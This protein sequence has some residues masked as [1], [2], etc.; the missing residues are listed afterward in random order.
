MGSEPEPV[1]RHRPRTLNEKR[2]EQAE[3]RQV[4]HFETILA[5]QSGMDEDPARST[6]AIIL[7]DIRAYLGR[8]GLPKR[9]SEDEVLKQLLE[10]GITAEPVVSRDGLA[11][12]TLRPARDAND[13]RFNRPFV[14][15]EFLRLDKRL[16]KDG[17]G[18]GYSGCNQKK[19][20]EAKALTGA[21]AREVT[22]REQKAVWR[23]ERL[24]DTYAYLLSCV[25]VRRLHTYMHLRMRVPAF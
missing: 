13:R 19:D 23:R 9:G 11:V 1:D 4:K 18:P 24:K 22:E 7:P 14:R 6:A 5:Q 20:H 3:D 8:V 17:G 10:A 25:Y 16:K 21:Y 12:F 15:S 2:S